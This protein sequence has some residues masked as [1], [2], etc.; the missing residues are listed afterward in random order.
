MEITN[1][2]QAKK[3]YFIGIKG[4]GMTALAQVLKSC[5]KKIFGSDTKEKFFTNEILRNLNI[6]VIEGFDKKNISD[7]IDC[8]I[9][10]AAYNEKNN[11]EFQEA[12]DKGLKI[13]DYAEALGL[14]SKEKFSISVTGTHGKTT[15]TA[16]LG[17]ILDQAGLDPTVIVGS[18]SLNWK[19]NARVGKSKY[20]VAET[21]EYQ[22]H[23]FNFHPK[24]VILTSVEWDHP[25]FFKTFEDYKKSFS[26][27][28]KKIPKNGFVIAYGDD[29]NV[30]EVVE[31]AEAKVIFYGKNFNNNFT[32][33]SLD[34]L[35]L[36][37]PGEYN[38]LNALAAFICAQK[39]G[40][41]DEQILSALKI[42]KGTA[43]RFEIKGGFNGG[44]I[45]DDYAHHP[46]E[47]RVFLLAC[48]EKY[49]D[50]KIWCVFHPHTFTRTKALFEDFIK[51]FGNADE[52]IVLD[53]YGSAREE[54]GGVSSQEL[55]D[56][57]KQ[58][59]VDAHFIPTI[60]KTVDFLRKNV[61]VDEIICTV[62][63]GD[64]WKVGEKLIEK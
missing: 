17:W 12:K 29:K 6:K 45:V 54:H 51:S 25:D 3:I 26:E 23:F 7:D 43:R 31:S 61:K 56:A 36:L 19:T 5:D 30:R 49:K 60:D 58:N 15:T 39:L 27:Y 33:H 14:L 28:I 34:D 2:E 4:V 32:M 55:A 16:M 9:S 8:V 11:V 46:T 53:I 10:S 59:G 52:V 18:Q 38:L 50:R 48:R 41:E 63:A 13:F 40:V 42:F 20:F 64:V 1:L 47:V 24:I 22:N 57:I 21:C 37:I 62:G 35:D 44:V